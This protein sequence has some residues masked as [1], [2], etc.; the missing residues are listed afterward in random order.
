M[1]AK[2]LNLLCVFFSVLAVLLCGCEHGEEDTAVNTDFMADFTAEYNNIKL[3]GSVINTRQDYFAAEI[4]S[5][6][7]LAGLSAKYEG[8]VLSLT[9]NGVGATADEAFMP[10]DSL[11]SIMHEIL[12]EAGEGKGIAESDGALK[13]PLS[14][15][16]AEMTLG[17][18]GFPL[19]AEIP[20]RGFSVTFS[21]CMPAGKQ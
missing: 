14:C 7:T 19:S 8:G 10:S 16:K 6:E 3:G 5:P 11:F 21:N 9:R 1:A 15:G 2:I 18:S 13:L 17:K 12:R 4:S 20:A